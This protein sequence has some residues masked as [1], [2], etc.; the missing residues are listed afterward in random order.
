MSKKWQQIGAVRKETT[1]SRQPDNF[2][3]GRAELSCFFFSSFRRNC[4]LLITEIKELLVFW[5]ISASLELE[6]LCTENQ[7]A[8]CVI[9]RAGYSYYIPPET[10][11]DF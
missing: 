7:I 2:P 8:L 10:K 5:K 4:A 9:G 3:F 6:R 11:V 1:P